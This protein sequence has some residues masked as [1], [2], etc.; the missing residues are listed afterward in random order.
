M[1]GS[2]IIKVF[3]QLITGRLLLTALLSATLA[4]GVAHRTETAQSKAVRDRVR[5]LGLALMSDGTYQFRLC[6]LH[7]TY[8]T[9]ILAEACINPLV[10]E[11]GSAKIFNDVPAKPGTALA[12][13]RNW[14][15]AGL[16]G[17]IA[18]TFLY[19]IG[20]FYVKGKAKDRLIGKTRLKRHETKVRE[21][22]QKA[23]EL[24]YGEESELMGELSLLNDNSE[25][26]DYF[27]KSKDA[28]NELAEKLLRVEDAIKKVDGDK[29]KAKAELEGRV[30]SYNRMHRDGEISDL[31][32][33]IDSAIKFDPEENT[34][35]RE[36]ED[37]GYLADFLGKSSDAIKRRAKFMRDFPWF[38]EKTL[39]YSDKLNK[40]TITDEDDVVT[41]LASDK[42]VEN[43]EVQAGA[44]KLVAQA[45]GIGALLSLPL[46][47]WSRY[48][49]GHALLTA[50]KNWT[51]IT[52]GYTEAKRIDDVLTIL[53][54]IAQ[55]TDAKVAWEAITNHN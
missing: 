35:R 2:S 24:G 18:G 50:E 41:K 38:D 47:A 55:A 9:Q 49:P 39:K 13:L 23:K 11:D 44:E 8:T 36:I 14:V 26:K 32:E 46:T 37:G 29:S 43:I 22:Q 3:L 33:K 10:N 51:A 17:A 42:R 30:K 21:A 45:V 19:K 54:G 16:A 25:M 31:G 7:E 12:R 53:D 27:L 15:T 1:L 20:R 48:L 28:S 4:C 52:A 34:L 40:I 5:V 6:R